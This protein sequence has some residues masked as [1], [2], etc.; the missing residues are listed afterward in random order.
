MT[1]FNIRNNCS[2]MCT[3]HRS[4]RYYIKVEP[5]W[6]FR[7]GDRC[8]WRPCSQNFNSSSTQIWLH[9]CMQAQVTSTTKN[10]TY[11]RLKINQPILTL[12]M[13]LVTLLGPQEEKETTTG[14]NASRMVVLLK[15]VAFGALL[16][17]KRVN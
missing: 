12:R 10:T 8:K 14:A 15:M 3:R 1:C 17:M 6:I 9:V 5:L 16:I 4:P 2:G 7:Q 13:S 11:F